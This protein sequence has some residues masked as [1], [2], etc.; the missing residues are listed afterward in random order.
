MPDSCRGQR[1]VAERKGERQ[2]LGLPKPIDL[3]DAAESGRNLA[4]LADG[5]RPPGPEAHLHARLTWIN[6]AMP[7]C[8]IITLVGRSGGCSACV[9]R[10]PTRF[11]GG[12]RAE[13]QSHESQGHHDPR[14]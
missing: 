2:S 6:V 8:P 1:T 10:A 7:A 11:A 13:D 12:P 5:L 14:C 9:S 3:D 4:V